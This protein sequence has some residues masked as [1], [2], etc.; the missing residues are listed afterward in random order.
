MSEKAG[1]IYFDTGVD[2][3]GL[4]SGLNALSVAAGNIISEVVQ[5]IANGMQQ[6][7]QAA[8]NEGAALEQ[9]IGGVETLFEDSAGAVIAYA[10]DAYKTA[11]LSANAYMETVTGFAASLLQ[12]LEGDTAQAAEIANMAV[13]DMSDNANKMGTSM[14]AIQNAYQGFAK[15]NYTMLD[16]LKLGYGGTKTEMERLLAEAEKLSGIKY[17]IN[18][19]SDVYSAI[20]VIQEDLRISG[21]TAEEA[22]EMVAAGLMTEEE[23]FEALGTTAKEASNTIAGSAAAMKSAFANVLGDLT[24][25]EDMSESLTALAETASTYLFDN[26]LPA[27]DNIKDALPDALLTFGEKMWEAGDSMVADMA[28]GMIENAESLLETGAALLEKLI[29]GIGTN[30]PLLVQHASGLVLRFADFFSQNLPVVLNLGVQLLL[31]LVNGIASSL[32]QLIHSAG[33]II[34]QLASE[35]IANLPTIINAGIDILFSLIEGIGNSLPQLARTA[36]D[37]FFTIQNSLIRLAPQLLE[38]GFKLVTD[39]IVGIFDAESDLRQTVNELAQAIWD[40]IDDI[41]WIQ[42]G[43][44]LIQGLINGIS[45]MAGALWDAAVNI[46]RSTFDAAKSAL[47][48]N[49]P[50]RLFRDEIGKQIPAGAAEGVE[51]NA[52]VAIDAARQSAEDMFAAAREAAASEQARYSSEGSTGAANARSAYTSSFS[53]NVTVVCEMDGREVARGTAP[54]MDEQMDLL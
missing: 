51:D 40:C 29:E 27:L 52:Q 43:K 12:G 37:L 53:G 11:G 41:D 13:T 21:L 7:V 1:S 9:S 6:M 32:P 25:G 39:L 19:L 38:T 45:Y 3:S 22:A 44:D 24:L 15:Q 36:V 18:N 49:S 47:G 14:E 23:A 26:L 31:S 42:L 35:I 10:E 16:N 4:T 20:H 33:V 46:A 5:T 28:Y 48:I 54:F 2:G 50:S 30:L 8:I 34:G 17:D